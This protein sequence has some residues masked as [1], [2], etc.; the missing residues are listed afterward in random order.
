MKALAEASRLSAGN[1]KPLSLSAYTLAAAGRV[2]EARALLTEMEEASR[3]RY[4]PPYAFALV[5]AG[6][7]DERRAFE[8]LEQAAIMRDAH[9]IYVIVD[10]KWDRLRRAT[11]FQ[12]LVRRLGLSV[13]A[14]PTIPA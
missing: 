14:R 12:E 4:V 13:D 9:L 6:L 10:P 11:R 2:S 8:S 7:N 1:S 5:Y 3:V